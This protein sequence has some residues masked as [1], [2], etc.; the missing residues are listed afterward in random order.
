MSRTLHHPQFRQLLTQCKRLKFEPHDIAPQL[1]ARGRYDMPLPPEFSFAV[2]LFHYSS[3]HHT[4]GATWHERLELFMPL[5]GRVL[6]QMGSQTTEL[7]PG[8]LLIV[9]NMKLHH[10]VDFPG[11]DT[12]A[13]VVS[14]QPEFVYS[15]GS[16]SHDYTFLLP[17]YAS[18][19]REAR[20][21]SILNHPD[22][23]LALGRL[24]RW[25][26]EEK[27]GALRRA[28]CKASLLGLLLELAAAF[29]TPEVVR[30]EFLRQ[31]ERSLRL[32]KLFEHISRHYTERLSIEDAARIA[33]MSPPQF[34]KTFR[35]VAGMP[36]TA[37]L[38]HVRLA[39][40]SRLLLETSRTIAEIALEV[41]FS[42]QSYFDKRFKRAFG[43]T[44]RDFRLGAMPSL[45][46][47]S[48]K[49]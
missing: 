25:S 43:Q 32:K 12:R 39:N 45:P 42:D 49:R 18:T 1:D 3:R 48:A 46:A 5:D 40:A 44:P 23:A 13:I 29:H 21:M 14:F 41:G 7:K 34:M 36:L 10:V 26:F 27:D 31:Q 16:P 20:V 15:L 22:A 19:Q 2:K 28:G 37:Y 6:F 35:R 30:W 9:D 24:L 4:R 33:A 38:N 47:T 8:D 11:F 17:F